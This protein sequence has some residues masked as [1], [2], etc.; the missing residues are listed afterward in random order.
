M[1]Q[2]LTTGPIA[3][4]LL[5]F[6]LPLMIG[7]LLQQ[8][9]N[10]CDT[11]VVGRF[12]GPEALA[13]VGSSYALM[14]FLTSIFLG[15]CMGSGAAFAIQYGRRDEEQLKSSMFISF[16]LIALVT[17]LLN[18]AV[19]AGLDG[20]IQLLQVSGEVAPLMHD[21][22]W[23]IFWGM[24]AT[25]L[26]NY[27]ANLLRAVGDS[28]TPLA[29]LG[30][31]AILNVVLDL[32]FVLIFAWGIQGAAIATVIAQLVA[33]L[34]ILVYTLVRFPQLRLA[35]RHLRWHKQI[36]VDIAGLSFLTCLQQS[37]MNFGILMVQGL[38][39]SFGTVVMAA[40]AA[41]VKIDA[42]AYLPVQ[43]FGNAFATY[44]AQNHGA[45]Q[46]ERIEQGIRSAAVTVFVFC[47]FISLGV[48]LL[49]RPL[50]EIFVR[51]E[52][53]AIIAAGV[54]YLRIEASFYLGIG[55][56][57]L[58]YGFYRA[59]NRPAMSVVLTVISLGTRVI[60]A[61]GL[62]AIPAIGVTGIWAAVPIGWILA[63]LV[64]ILYY[65]K[66]RR[67]FLGLSTARLKSA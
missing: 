9:Y 51:P 5:R 7:N 27:F 44:V 63:D 30:V 61:Y 4:N 8:L 66:N 47:L 28:L 67:R 43:D 62:S 20:I 32:I 54:H 38:V 1:P 65:R 11:W 12:L 6:A 59:I 24:G 46:G 34:G 55:I 15:L 31:S 48:C 60:L 41:A 10:V 26:Y 33:G 45:G 18:V 39:N 23:I 40:F 36:A 17:L 22:L 13:A 37:V 53:T 2:D 3:S 49:A 56:L 64:G 14:V 35:R 16:V 19:F 25:F 58:L 29:F 21:Y 50:M 52:E 42:F 57:F